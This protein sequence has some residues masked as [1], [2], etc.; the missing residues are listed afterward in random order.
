[1]AELPTEGRARKRQELLDS[2]IEESHTDF[3][4]QRLKYLQDCVHLHS[5]LIMF[6]SWSGVK[7]VNIS[8]LLF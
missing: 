7:I 3:T 8:C 4:D 5:S 1:M 6:L 2:A